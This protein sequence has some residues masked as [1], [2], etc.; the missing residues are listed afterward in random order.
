MEMQR[1]DTAT[2]I[3]PA[4]VCIRGHVASEDLRSHAANDEHCS[5]CQGRVLR[6]CPTCRGHLRADRHPYTATQETPAGLC[7][8]CGSV[9]PWASWQE[10]V[11]ALENAIESEQLDASTMLRLRLILR[12]LGASTPGGDTER[13]LWQRLV[14]TLPKWSDRAW[15]LASPLISAEIKNQLGLTGA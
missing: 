4:A 15:N 9:L 6:A 3:A 13:A 14:D 7:A 5:I 2:Q 8:A 10:R 1:S 11:W 12:E